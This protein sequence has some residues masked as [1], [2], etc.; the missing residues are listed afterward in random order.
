VVV[1]YIAILKP[2][3]SLNTS[4]YPSPVS[5]EDVG[6]ATEDEDGGDDLS[7]LSQHLSDVSE[8]VL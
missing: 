7:I 5:G 1:V 2:K 8:D 4:E 3:E 6:Q